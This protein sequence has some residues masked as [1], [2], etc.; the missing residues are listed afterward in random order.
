MIRFRRNNKYRKDRKKDDIRSYD[1]IKRVNAYI[2]NY[3]K[4]VSIDQ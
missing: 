1:S 3:I 2:Y 4:G